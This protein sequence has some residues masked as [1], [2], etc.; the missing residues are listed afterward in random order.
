MA[1]YQEP[2][3][4]VTAEA[5]IDEFEGG[6]KTCFMSVEIE[7]DVPPVGKLP[8]ETT[9]KRWV[10]DS[11]CSQLMMPSADYMG[12]Y[13]EDGSVVRTADSRAMPIEGIENLPMS[14]WPG[15]DWVQ[16]VLPNIAHV[17]LL[18]YNLLS[19]KRMADRGHEYVGEK[20]GVAFHLKNG[21]SIF[22]HSVGKV[23]CLSGFRRPLD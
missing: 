2:D 9:V 4:E 22:C 8:P 23:N 13:C 17:P 19:L 7:K 18:G 6:G 12:N 15:Q 21:K 20:K 10:A 16:V 5:K 11:G 1:V 14:F 3:S